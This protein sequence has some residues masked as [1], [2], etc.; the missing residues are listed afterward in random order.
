MLIIGL[1]GGVATGKSTVSGL[2]KE[3]GIPVID[4]DLVARQV[5]QPGF[6]AYNKL[7]QE[8]GSEY[9]DDESGGVLRRDKLGKL[10]FNNPAARKKLNSITHPAIRWEMLKLFIY[11]FFTSSSYIVFDTPLLFEVGYD[12]WMPSIAVWCDRDKELSRMMKRD[13]LSEEDALSRINAQ[14]DIEE[15]KKRATYVL[16]NNGNLEQLNDKVM[17]LMAQ[18]DSSRVPQIIR[19]V[20][21]F[22]V[23]LFGY[24]F[25]RKVRLL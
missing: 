23:G 2:F 10:I 4:A 12:K 19:M 25:L 18:L 16:D 5:V 22:F 7:R 20:F 15:K 1:S 14:M 21:T 24:F 9:F 6:P 8:F 17:E 13:N 3:H 11:H